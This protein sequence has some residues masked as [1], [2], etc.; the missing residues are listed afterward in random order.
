MQRDACGSFFFWP[1]TRVAAQNITAATEGVLGGAARDAGL[2]A[3]APLT[4]E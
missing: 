2:S 4:L 3:A 1:F